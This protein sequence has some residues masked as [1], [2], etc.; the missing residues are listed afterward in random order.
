MNLSI[1][2]SFVIGGLMLLSILAF[3]MR[4]TSSTQ[5]TTLSTINQQKMDNL[6]EIISYDINRI[7]YNNDTSVDMDDPILTAED[8]EIEFQ[9]S[10]GDIRWYINT[11]DEVST[12]S[13]PND[14]Y[15]YRDDG[16]GV[17]SKFPVT[18]FSLKYYDKDGAEISDISSIRQRNISV[19]IKLV[20]ESA[21]PI[22]SRKS[23]SGI[24]DTYHRTAWN[25]VFHP[26][27][28]NKPWY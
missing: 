22:S 18:Y 13:N 24:S 2:T 1:I 25:R 26:T 3:N 21:E 11:G 8:D 17:D 6:V 28:I 12:T 5:E 9:T 15:L 27:N 19:E 14:F 10:D 20:V 16:P 4:L 7:G 23:S